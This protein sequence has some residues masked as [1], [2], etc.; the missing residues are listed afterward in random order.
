MMTAY[1]MFHEII[2]KDIA[3]TLYSLEKI[4]WQGQITHTILEL[5]FTFRPCGLIKLN[6]PMKFHENIPEGNESSYI[7]KPGKDILVKVNDS[8]SPRMVF[9]IITML[10]HCIC[11][12]S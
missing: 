2:P 11:E 5:S 7:V 9:H 3:S 1:V 6:A 12:V 10:S 4:F 8:Y